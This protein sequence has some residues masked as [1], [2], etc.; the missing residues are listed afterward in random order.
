MSKI[1]LAGLACLMM[2]GAAQ[3]QTTRSYTVDN[4][5][6]NGASGQHSA[7]V[8]DSVGDQ[9]TITFAGGASPRLTVASSVPAPDGTHTDTQATFSYIATLTTAA[10]QGFQQ[11]VSACNSRGDGRG[12]CGRGSLNPIGTATGSYGVVGTDNTFGRVSVQVGDSSIGGSC[13]A[14]QFGNA[15]GIHNYS[16]DVY[17]PN[18]WLCPGPGTCS[19][20]I[21]VSTPPVFT[22]T[23]FVEAD[24]GQDGSTQQMTAF[25]D[26]LFT[27]N[28]S[29]F[30]GLGLDP[31]NYGLSLS[32]TIE[33]GGGV[34]EPTSWAMMLL[35]FA[36]LGVVL[37]NRS[38]ATLAA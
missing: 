3:A 8:I 31:R 30:T 14:G 24:V 27:L 4:Q 11:L 15:C 23:L 6:P 17:V 5:D 36:G 38:R 35:G 25:A 2:A 13:D 29:F 26:P 10:T 21:L 12:A 19:S 33:G 28:D 32:P 9:S 34:P 7:T 22:A 1:F 18:D 16:L 37:R 20:D